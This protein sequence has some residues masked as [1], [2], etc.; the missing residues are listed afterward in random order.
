MP[1]KNKIIVLSRATGSVIATCAKTMGLDESRDLNVVDALYS[2]RI[3][4]KQKT[5]L[6]RELKRIGIVKVDVTNPR[7]AMPVIP[8]EASLKRKPATK[9]QRIGIRELTFHRAGSGVHCMSWTANIS[10]VVWPKGE[11]RTIVREDKTTY[12]AVA[13]KKERGQ[14]VITDEDGGFEFDLMKPH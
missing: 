11:W 10:G 3:G 13:V 6:L 7:C 2:S 9:F 14:I 5:I 12:D 8:G 1:A 4:P